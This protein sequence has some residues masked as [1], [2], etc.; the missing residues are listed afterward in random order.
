M[1]MV[2]KSIRNG[3]RLDWVRS[4]KGNGQA[5][6]RNEKERTGWEAAAAVRGKHHGGASK[7]A[8]KRRSSAAARLAA[9]ARTRVAARATFD[10]C[11]PV[12]VK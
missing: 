8:R 12:D 5:C 6:S 10:W 11:A 4:T 7:H 1:Y 9:C 2:G 3:G